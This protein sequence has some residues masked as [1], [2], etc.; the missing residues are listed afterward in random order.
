MCVDRELCFVRWM[1][2]AR[3]VARELGREL[4]E[5]ERRGPFP[6]YRWARQPRRRPAGHPPA[7]GPHYGVVE[8]S[9]VLY[10]APMLTGLGEDPRSDDPLFRLNVD[11]WAL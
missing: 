11:M 3:A 5:E 8:A 9:T 2:T 4:T 1:H 10:A 6:L 7:R